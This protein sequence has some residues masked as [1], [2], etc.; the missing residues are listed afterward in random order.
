MKKSV[1]LMIAMS[2]FVS[3]AS[4]EYIYLKSGEEIIGKITAET[5]DSITVS[6]GGK[7]RKLMLKN[8][9]EIS[10]KKKEITS[11]SKAANSEAGDAKVQFSSKAKQD[12]PDSQVYVSDNKSGIIVY[13]VKE[14]TVEKTK[15]AKSP[16][17]A[18]AVSA[19][20]DDDDEFDAAMYLLSGGESGSRDVS[21]NTA[22]TLEKEDSEEPKSYVQGQSQTDD[23]EYD[24]VKYLLGQY[25]DDYFDAKEESSDKPVKA[26]K[27]KK[28]KKQKEKKQKDIYASDNNDKVRG[29]KE[30][31]DNETFIAASFDLKG[32]HIVTG[33]IKE[34]GVESSADKTENSDYGISI[35]VEQYAY[36]SRFAA[37]GLGIG[38]EFNRCLEASS[39]RFSFLTL[40]AAFKMRVFTREDYYF[41][42][43]AHLGYNFVIANS[44]YLG[45]A[46]ADGGLYYAG[47]IGATYNKYVFQVLYSVNHAHFEYSNSSVN[48]SIDKD[49]MYSKVGFYVGY[50]F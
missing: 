1:I 38:Y 47:G 36:L 34:F 27:A 44:S 17:S 11:A 48:D 50:L 16:E 33:D 35:A 13:N 12:L 29:E 25:G 42:A 24:P 18:A 14:T 40:Y 2:F 21:K 30:K 20:S 49:L 39:G 31:P 15:T 26:E 19:Q 7:K 28:E 9:D 3:V 8:I 43:V 32:V 41:Y 23:E 45:R 4:A 46:S 10:S 5:N 22:E 6:V 37:V